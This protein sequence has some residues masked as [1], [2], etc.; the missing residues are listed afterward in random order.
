MTCRR[1]HGEAL[2]F[3]PH[4][5]LPAGSGSSG[6]SR[7]RG[8]VPF[9]PRCAAPE[10]SSHTSNRPV[11]FFSKGKERVDHAEDPCR[12]LRARLAAATCAGQARCDASAT[13]VEMLLAPGA[14]EGFKAAAASSDSLRPSF[15]KSA[16]VPTARVALPSRS[17]ASV[18]IEDAVTGWPTIF[19]V[20][21]KKR[22]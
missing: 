22:G 21:E 16:P 19:G 8:K 15:G 3:I 12:R 4:A 7:N 5:V 13:D 10:D 9:G 18:R 2:F 17:K 11:S 20:G 14:A 6:F 1:R